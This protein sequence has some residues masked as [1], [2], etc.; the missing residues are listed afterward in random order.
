MEG[1]LKIA[2]IGFYG[3][4]GGAE[5]VMKRDINLLIEA[6]HE[7]AVIYG[8]RKVSSDFQPAVKKYHLEG[9]RPD[10]T[11][12]GRGSASFLD[13]LKKEKPDIVNFHNCEIFED[14][15]TISGIINSY[16]SVIT[17]YNYYLWCPAKSKSRLLKNDAIC[18]RHLGLPCLFC[19]YVF[20]GQAAGFRTMVR[21]YRKVKQNIKLHNRAARIVVINEHMREMLSGIGVER[22]K[23]SIVTP[24]VPG[25]DDIDY[26]G[27]GAR[28]NKVLFVGR[29]CYIKGV[30]FL[31]QAS[32]YIETDHAISIIG[33]GDY[34]TELRNM[35]KSLGIDKRVVFH[36]EV[37]DTVR[38][39]EY[40]TAAL[41]VVPSIWPETFGLIG[42][43]AISYGLPVVAF[44]VG[45]ISTSWC[46]DGKN[47]YLVNPRDTRML[48]D[49]INLLLK[50]RGLASRMSQ[51][52]RRIALE[53]FRPKNHIKALM[54]AY[55]S[56]CC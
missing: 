48:A 49:K 23:I 39:E 16:P 55:H 30:Q 14:I 47:G 37:D 52:S 12:G 4:V 51:E 31:L 33:G 24:S 27:Y 17:V 26:A 7:V 18:Q 36:G 40:R 13:I 54:E 15:D 50:D 2:F 35:A 28:P 34:L 8:D 56:A 46:F 1:K 22:D 10:F 25:I 44:D 42:Q 9:M 53:L 38:N 3:G 43:E 19:K 29:I 41:M 45:G 5:N 11:V 32:R 6:G 20:G 21:R